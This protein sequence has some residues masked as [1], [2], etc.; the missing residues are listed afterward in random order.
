MEPFLPFGKT[1]RPAAAASMR[2]LAIGVLLAIGLSAC[3][4][5]NPYVTRPAEPVADGQD[6]A[7]VVR[8]ADS[9]RERGELTTA[10]AF[11]QRAAAVSN[12]ARELI[13]LGRALSE[14]G[15]HERAAGAFRQ[16][17]SRESDHPDALLGLGTAY[18]SLGQVDKSIQY[19]QQL[20][21]QGDGADT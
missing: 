14:V 15:V 1:L 16:A 4:G 8:L 7:S 9:L 2:G 12:D 5:G 10:I 17:L 20:V 11:Y 13:L 3:G 6:V 21:D 19:L 18:L